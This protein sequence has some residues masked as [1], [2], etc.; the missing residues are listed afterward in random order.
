MLADNRGDLL[1]WLLQFLIYYFAARAAAEN[2]YNKNVR[3]GQL[4]AFA[5]VQVPGLA[6]LW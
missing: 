2:Q 5:G 3:W 4:G 6:R 1:S